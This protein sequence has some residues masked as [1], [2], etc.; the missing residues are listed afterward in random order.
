MTR[1]AIVALGVLLAV[2]GSAGTARVE[3]AE[4]ECAVPTALPA[5]P[6]ER[7]RYVLRVR[8]EPGLRTASGTLV[9][10]FRAPA[11]TDR[12]VL[13]LWPNGPF[14]AARG[15]RLDVGA[16]T[17]GGRRVATSRPDPTTLVVRRSLSVGARVTLSMPWTLRLP[18]G[19]GF[20][21]HGG[22]S[23]RLVSFF[24]LLAWD[25]AG[26]AVDAPVPQLD[27]FWPTSPTADF[28][29]TVAVPA[30]L[31]VLG[32]GEETRPG[33]WR[34]RAVRDFALV[35]GR[36]RFAKA[37]VSAPDPVRMTVAVE[38]RSSALVQAFVSESR[39]V[40]RHYAERY[41]DYPW[42]TYTLVVMADF[43]ALAGFA[44]PMLGVVGDASHVLVPHETAH[45]WFLALIGNNQSRDPWLSEGLASW[46]QTGPEGSLATMLATRIPPDV[47]NRLGNPVSFFARL[48]FEKLR[49]GVY[50]QT[51]KALSGLGATSVVDCALRRFVIRNAY[52]TVVPRDLL[53]ALEESFPAAGRV[54]RARGARL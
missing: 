17:S 12:V 45:Q 11:P 47:R 39:R 33:R 7:P 36:F 2:G 32:T 4:P 31:Q 19:N 20:Q 3:A 8:V 54:L 49:L 43:P 50:V 13:R 44:Y 24:P 51:V 40:L 29:A 10:S 30:G 52:R 14:Y 46:A 18:R 28:D 37:V 34:A 16:M 27:S 1:A 5:P 9:V 25:G 23:A 15:A 41:G 48:G 6:A 21:L 26:W 42:P 53:A 35:V 22:N 38:R